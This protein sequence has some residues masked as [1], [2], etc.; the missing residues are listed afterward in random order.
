MELFSRLVLHSLDGIVF[1]WLYALIAFGLSLIF[2]LLNIVN[3]AHGTLYMLGAVFGWYFGGALSGG[4]YWVALICAPLIV[5]LFSVFLELVVLRP[6]EENTD[7]T[8]LSTFGILLV[9]ENIVLLWIGGQGVTFDAPF[10]AQVPIAGYRYSVYRL[11][12]MGFAVMTSLILWWFLQKT[13]YGLWIRA[14][15]MNTELSLADGIPV[16]SVNTVAFALGGLLAGL[17]GVLAGPFVAV[18]P[19]MGLNV[20][21]IA[22]IVVIVGGLGDPFG[23]V[24]AGIILGLVESLASIFME[25]TLARVISLLFVTT[26]LFFRPNGLFGRGR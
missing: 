11:F 17:S 7:M 10:E 9:V 25:P 5:C 21:I 24:L 20:L 13:R 2:G 26:F 22:F 4:N 8:I 12:V 23:A 15:R 1:G 6:I 3:V 19:V 18:S 16:K 14:V